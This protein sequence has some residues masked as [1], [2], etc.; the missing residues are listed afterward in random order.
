MSPDV[1]EFLVRPAQ[2]EDEE[3]LLPLAVELATS[4]VPER[5]A[6]ARS[7]AHVLADDAA[8]VLVATAV[9]PA[10]EP[11]GRTPVVGYVHV[12][13]HPAFHANGNVGW[14]EEVVV[15]PQ[16]RGSGCGRLLLEAAGEWARGAGAVYVA[17]AT[18]R[19]GE[20]YRALGFEESAVYFKKPS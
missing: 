13:V 2:P 18:R 6:F 8:T 14:V 20:F 11:A 3:A 9:E 19:A 16:F 1:P 7:L 17:L 5:V 15:A 10:V 12:L 4:F